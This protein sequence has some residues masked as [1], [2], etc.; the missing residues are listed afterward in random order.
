MDCC[1]ENNEKMNNREPAEEKGLFS[2]LIYGLMPHTA[3]IGFIV[4]TILG[5]TTATAIFRPL[6]LNPYFF[7][8]LIAISFVFATISATIYLRKNG[9][10]SLQGIKDKKGY[11]TTL[12]GSTIAINLLLFMFIFPIVTNISTGSGIIAS[13]IG[14]FGESKKAQLSDSEKVVTLQVDIPCSGHAPLITEDLRKIDGVENVRFRFPNL[15][16]VEYVVNNTSIDSIISL[17]I[18]NTYEATIVEETNNNP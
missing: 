7:H 13:T 17:D 9:V 16:D 6:L 4:F 8:I 18:F 15:F 1:D 11:L 10:L 3:C 5:V 14:V 12:Y 2:G